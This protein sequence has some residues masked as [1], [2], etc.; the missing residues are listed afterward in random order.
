MNDLFQ[1]F[2][3]LTPTLITINGREAM[4]EA[5]TFLSSR[6]QDLPEGGDAALLRLYSIT[7]VGE[8]KSRLLNEV[9]VIE[10]IGQVSFLA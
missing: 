4:I 1:G 9:E 2:K 6:E 8:N 7:Y 3:F 5:N 10:L